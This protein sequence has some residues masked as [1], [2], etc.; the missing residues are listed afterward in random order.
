MEGSVFYF[1]I[2]ELLIPRCDPKTRFNLIRTCKRLWNMFS[3]VEKEWMYIGREKPI[4][5]TLPENYIQCPLC[6]N[7]I[8]SGKYE[9]HVNKCTII[10]ENVKVCYMCLLTYKDKHLI[11][12]KSHV[13]FRCE[14][15]NCKNCPLLLVD[16][17]NCKGIHLAGSRKNECEICKTQIQCCPNSKLKRC[18][19]HICIVCKEGI[20]NNG[21]KCKLIEHQLQALYGHALF[22]KK[23]ENVYQDIRSKIYFIHVKDEHSIPNLL[24]YIDCYV[25]IEVGKHI[26]RLSKSKFYSDN[27]NHC[28]H[29]G[30]TINIK[31][32][33]RCKNIYYC[34]VICQSADWKI[35]K[36][37][38]LAKGAI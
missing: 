7:I 1:N 8:R 34:S 28:N 26:M 4:I 19:L 21:H 27:L 24:D 3:I 31:K 10:R 36:I 16:C 18:R 11:C 22:V 13:C 29:C 20:S 15:R 33:S 38:C 30:T 6:K 12:Q 2:Y 23:E 32:C 14:S 25:F 9:N 37:K 5:N 35:H 17:D